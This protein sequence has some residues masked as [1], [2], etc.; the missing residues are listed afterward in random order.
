MRLHKI[1]TPHISS[2]HGDTHHCTPH[3]N[4]STQQ[5]F[6]TTMSG[7]TEA[8]AEKAAAPTTSKR[9]SSGAGEARHRVSVISAAAAAAVCRRTRGRRGRFHIGW[10]RPV[11]RQSTM[12]HMHAPTARAAHYIE[13]PR[14]HIVLLASATGHSH[15][16]KP[17]PAGI[18]INAGSRQRGTSFLTLTHLHS[19]QL[20]SWH[21]TVDVR[22]NLCTLPHTTQHKKRLNSSSSRVCAR[23]E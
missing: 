16:A 20:I 18:V 13:A 21:V 4:T 15:H 2:A 7:N 5:P 12:T 9:T 22:G 8:S 1:L 11:L 17:V 6:M 23:I 19:G 10:E 3:I 14:A